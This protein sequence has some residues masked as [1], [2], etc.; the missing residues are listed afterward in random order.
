MRQSIAVCLPARCYAGDLGSFHFVYTSAHSIP[1]GSKLRFDLL[2]HGSETEW[3]LPQTDLKRKKNLI[4]IEMEDKKI[5]GASIVEGAEKEKLYEFRLPSEVKKGESFTIILGSPSDGDGNRCQ[6][7]LQRRRAFHLY[8]D[9]LKDKGDSKIP[10]I[11]QINV[12]GNI[13]KNI[14]II[15]PSLVEKNS[16]FHLSIRFEDQYSNLT[17]YAPEGSLIQLSYAQQRDNFNWKLFIPETGLLHLPNLQFNEPGIYIIQLLNIKTEE[18][19]FSSPIKCV[20]FAKY[21]IYWGLFHSEL[22]RPFFNL[23]SCLHAFRD[24][25][26]LHFYSSSFYGNKE[27]ETEKSW[28][29]LSESIAQFNED[30][31]FSAFLG[32]QYLAEEGLRQI[33]YFKDQKTFFS[34]KEAKS[35]SLSKLYKFL[36]PKESVSIL[37]STMHPG[38]IT[39]FK[40]IDPELEKLVEIYNSSGSSE[41]TIEEG[42]L[43]PIRYSS[44]EERKAAE[45]GSILN[46]LKKNHRFGFVAGGLDNKVPLRKKNKEEKEEKWNQYSPG[47][48]AI[49]SKEQTREAFVQALLARACYATTGEKIIIDFSIAGVGIGGELTTQS[50]PGLMFNRHIAGYVVGCAPLKEVALIRNGVKIHLFSIE[51]NS[52]DFVYDDEEELSKI[53]LPSPDQRPPFVFYYLRVLQENGH[54]GWSSPIWIDCPEIEGKNGRKKQQK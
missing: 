33:L 41:T 16:K 23:D 26:S 21:S 48:T 52:S 51:D 38:C 35:S 29:Q 37:I 28:K 53:L 12:Q 45:S 43:H 18:R 22:D 54:M 13:L 36:N 20:D 5:V 42:N 44:K 14:R 7:N 34:N 15:A 1:E 32:F 50:K 27:G 4:W 8:I 40:K 46:A 47:L 24:E 25:H 39:D 10:E 19:F 6:L 9:N 11:F 2:S 3:E 49:L 30:Y 31:R 17:N